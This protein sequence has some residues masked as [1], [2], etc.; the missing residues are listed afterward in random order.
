MKFV[1]EVK[2]RAEAETLAMVAAEKK[3]SQRWSGRM[4]WG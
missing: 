1:D 3:H 2:I 4:R